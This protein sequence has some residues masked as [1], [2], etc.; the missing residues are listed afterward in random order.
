MLEVL[1]KGVRGDITGN[2]CIQNTQPLFQMHLHHHQ[3]ISTQ[4]IGIIL[5]LMDQ[6]HHSLMIVATQI[7]S[8]F[9]SKCCFHCFSLPF[10]RALD[11]YIYI[12]KCSTLY[13]RAGASVAFS[14]TGFSAGKFG[15][16]CAF[17]LGLVAVI[18]GLGV[19]G[20]VGGVATYPGSE[21]PPLLSEVLFLKRRLDLR[22]EW[23]AAHVGSSDQ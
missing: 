2:T 13:L 21:M 17:R 23:Q 6:T 1:N 5:H 19:I 22:P 18:W 9:V 12:N 20:V 3:H 11:I 10:C 7:C 15:Q 4:H 14:S 16:A 8:F